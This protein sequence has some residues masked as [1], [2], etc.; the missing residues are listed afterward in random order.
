[1]DQATEWLAAAEALAPAAKLSGDDELYRIA[2]R[3]QKRAL[4]R[5]GELLGK[6]DDLTPE[7]RKA[8]ICLAAVPLELFEEYVE[9]DCPLQT[10]VETGERQ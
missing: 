10:L 6:R 1:M 8:A 4:R 3:I 7:Q 9:D 2:H 5:M